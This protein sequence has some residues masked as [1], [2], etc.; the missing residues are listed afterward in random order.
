MPWKSLKPSYQWIP[1]VTTH[2][3]VQPS[4]CYVQSRGCWSGPLGLKSGL[5]RVS[6]AWE[7]VS[8]LGVEWFL[9]AWGPVALISAPTK[10]AGLWFSGALAL[11]L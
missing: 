4:Q 6:L 1:P 7:R 10:M 11:W 2:L 9:G 5:A 8:I 3:I